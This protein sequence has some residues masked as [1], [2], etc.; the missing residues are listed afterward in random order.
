MVNN[1][2]LVR[3]RCALEVIKV[4]LDEGLGW[5]KAKIMNPDGELIL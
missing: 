2:I 3:A 5:F 1:G 4:G